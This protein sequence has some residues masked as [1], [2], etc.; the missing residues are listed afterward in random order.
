MEHKGESGLI[1]DIQRFSTDDG[2]GIRSTVFLKGCNLACLWCHNPET[3][4]SKKQLR[5]TERDCRRCGSCAD[6]CP[7]KAHVVGA[8]GHRLLRGRCD[9][10]LQ[11]VSVCRFGALSVAGRQVS[12]DEVCAEV[13]RDQDFYRHSGGG[14]T[15]SGGEPLMQA[16]FC[17]AVLKAFRQKG[18]HTAIDTA[19]CVPPEC[20]ERVLPY[21]NLVLFDLKLADSAKHREMTG[22]D[23]DLIRQNLDS[24]C[25]QDVPI[26]IRI[27]LIAGINDSLQDIKEIIPLLAGRRNIEKVQ[28][29][30]YHAF[31]LGKYAD[32][33]M[34]SKS[35][36]CKVPPR[37]TVQ[38]ALDIFRDA[39]IKNAE[40]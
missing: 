29:L 26:W 21:T 18:I 11:C 6:V 15:L 34:E 17:A 22:G 36:I 12:V 31:G 7:S 40:Y 5:Y 27:P 19:G 25:R 23:N 10:C 37:E 3:I 28:L 4:S 16:D 39:G 33:G 8:E 32:L 13:L 20:F 14:V 1:T 2:P 35:D 38:T 24:L 30:A 9:G